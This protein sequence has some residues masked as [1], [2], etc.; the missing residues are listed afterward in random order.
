MRHLTT[1]CTVHAC[2]ATAK[3]LLTPLCLLILCICP[4]SPLLPAPAFHAGLLQAVA[5][6]CNVRA[7]PTFQVWKDGAM[8]QELV[9][10]DKNKLKALVEKWATA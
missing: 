2:A 5:G 8:V 10:A 4:C 7:M 9:G 6:A 3:N 1:A